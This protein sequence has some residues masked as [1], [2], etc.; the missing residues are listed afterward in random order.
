VELTGWHREIYGDPSIG[1]TDPGSYFDEHLGRVGPEHVWVACAEHEIVGMASLMLD[2]ADGEVD[3]LIVTERWRGR[4]IGTHLAERAT[5]EA[6][7]LGVRL[8]SVRPVAR[9]AEAIR[10]Y[11]AM[12]FDTVGHVELFM[13]LR[14]GRKGRW[15]PGPELCGRRFR[16]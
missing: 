15:I 5:Q 11:H 6:R 12:G 4:G 14:T 10:A 13:D 8:L 16:C 3:P 7:Q 2:G 9:N 1:G